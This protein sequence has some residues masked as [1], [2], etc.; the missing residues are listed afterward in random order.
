MELMV[1]LMNYANQE[2]KAE[3]KSYNLC[4]LIIKYCWCRIRQ[5]NFLRCNLCS[6][7][8]FRALSEGET[9]IQNAPAISSK[10]QRGIGQGTGR[11]Y[12]V[13]FLVWDSSQP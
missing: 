12:V 11:S 8:C 6:V 3:Q 2:D 13:T 1:I 9:L 7:L 5:F 4:I 10:K